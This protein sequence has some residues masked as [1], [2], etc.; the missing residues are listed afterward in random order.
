MIETADY[1]R[2]VIELYPNVAPKMV[3]R[4]KKLINEHFYD[5]T[6][7]HRVDVQL[8]IIQGGDPNTKGSNVATYGMG[9]RLIQTCRRSS[10]IF[11]TNAA[12]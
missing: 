1:G 7:I 10:V 12:R 8:G 5:G 3:E 2:I 11:L 4:F 6:A 9:G